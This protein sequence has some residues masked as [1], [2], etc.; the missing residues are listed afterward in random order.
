[1]ASNLDRYKQDFE[2]LRSEAISIEQAF[3]R[4]IYGR[5]YDE[6]VLNSFN[7]NKEKAQN[8]LESLPDFL[9]A[10]QSWYSECITLIKQLLPDRLADFIRH[11]EKPKGRK[12][13]NNENY[14]IEDALQGLSISGYRGGVLASPKSAIPQLQQQMAI[15]ESLRRRFESSLYDIRSLVQSDLFDSELDAASELLKHKFVRAAG[16]IAGVVLEKHLLQVCDNH[17]IKISKKHPAI[18][19]LNDALKE[20]SVIEVS[21]WRF[22]QH[23]ADIRNLCDHNKQKEPTAEQVGDLIGG[24]SKVSKTIY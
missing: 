17:A 10:Y 13:I 15:L 7:G 12:E 9:S 20:A 1:M 18:A 3:S 5:E 2:R 22:N 14:R 6:K 8:Y 4:Y 21:Q 11:Y 24:V 23:L 19:D 16:A